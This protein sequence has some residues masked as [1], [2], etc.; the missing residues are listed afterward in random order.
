MKQYI[1]MGQGKGIM[2]RKGGKKSKKPKGPGSPGRG[3]RRTIRHEA[4]EEYAD[5]KQPSRHPPEPPKI[6]LRL[7]SVEEAIGRLAAQLPGY[8]RQGIKEVLVV[9]G[10]GHNSIRGIS[11]LGPLVRQWCDDNPALVKSWREAPAYWGG[12]GAIVVVLH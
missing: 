10:K 1:L 3:K 9:H 8:S 6:H 4:Y 5:Q 7:I 2:G 11:V 12:S